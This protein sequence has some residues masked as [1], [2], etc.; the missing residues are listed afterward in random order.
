MKTFKNK[1]F[2]VLTVAVKHIFTFYLKFI[3]II[4]LVLIRLLYCRACV[5]Q[6]KIKNT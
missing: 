5:A 6:I 2:F 1:I 4:Y 3:I